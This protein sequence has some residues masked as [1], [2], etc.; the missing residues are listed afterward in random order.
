MSKIMDMLDT[1]TPDD[2]TTRD[3]PPMSR[4]AFTGALASLGD[5]CV[6][7]GALA[8]DILPHGIA[9]LGLTD[10]DADALWREAER[11]GWCDLAGITLDEHGQAGLVDPWG[12]RIPIADYRGPLADESGEDPWTRPMT[13]ARVEETTP[14]PWMEPTRRA[15]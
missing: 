7:G 1:T 13:A 14:D 5:R 11:R 8:H 2:P 4:E 6:S 3:L 15:E 9:T 10:A 12:D